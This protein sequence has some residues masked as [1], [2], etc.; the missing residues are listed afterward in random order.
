MP[1]CHCERGWIRAAA[2]QLLIPMNANN[3]LV[4]IPLK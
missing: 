4:F 2:N 3:G 1:S